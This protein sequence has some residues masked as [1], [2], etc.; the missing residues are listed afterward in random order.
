MASLAGRSLVSSYKELLKLNNLTPNSGVSASLQTV[1]DGFAGATAL[2]LSNAGIASTGTLAVTG[3]LSVN[4]NKFNVAAASGNTSVAGSLT[5]AGDLAV[6]TNKFNVTAAS[7]NTAVAGTLAV[8]GASTLNALSATTGSFSSTLSATGNLAINTNKFTVTAASGNTAAAG[9]LSAVGDF[10]INTNKFTVTAASGN[11]SSAGTLSVTGDLNVNTSKF[12]VL[13]STGNTSISG[14]LTVADTVDFASTGA[15]RIPRGTAGQ[16]PAGDTG[17]LRFNTNTQSFEG[18]NGVAWGAIGG[19]GGVGTS[20]YVRQTFVATAGQTSFTVT[21]GYTPDSVDVFQNGVKLVNGSGN[22]V[23]ITSGTAVVLATGAAAG[24][25]ID[26]IGLASGNFA[27]PATAKRQ[28]FIATAS[29]T[30]FTVTGG[31]TPNQLDVFQNGT[32]LVTSVDVDVSNGSTF[33]LTTPAVAGDSLEVVGFTAANTIAGTLKFQAGTAAAPSITRFEDENTGIFFPA[34]DT[35]AFSEGGAEAMRIDSSGQVGIGGT[36]ST[37]LH[38]QA[39]SPSLRIQAASGNSGALDFYRTASVNSGQIASEST[40]ALVFS[41]NGVGNSGL[42]ERLRIDSSGRVGIGTASPS[43]TLEVVGNQII[44]NT[45]D[46]DGSTQCALGIGRNTV[47]GDTFLALGTNQTNDYS[48]IQSQNA[49]NPTYYNL[50]LNPKGGNVKIGTATELLSSANRLEVSGTIGIGI[51]ADGGAES[52]CMLAWNS[53]AS[54]NNMFAIFYTEASPS[55]VGSIDFNRASTLTRYNTTSDATLKNI[56]GD[57]SGEESV[58]ILKN[59]KIRD[60]TWKKDATNKVN[61]GVVAQELYEVFKGAVSEGG[62]IVS[63]DSDGNDITTY[64]PWGVDKT[65][66]TFHLVA[67]W[68]A[69]EKL[70]QELKSENDSLKSRIE[71]LEAA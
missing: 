30:V 70:I 28:N 45:S 68:Q 69:H 59:T 49:G 2:Q 67:G 66:F 27:G 54:G 36:P 14:T 58:S 46:Q 4:T 39:T 15:M 51:K 53:A 32:K 44:K 48:F 33:T 12:S 22:D 64:R 21:G 61:V 56:I 63:K 65:A 43:A 10:A 71:A 16:R 29:Q 62:D 11:V 47:A 25:V 26:V 5:A 57:S 1:E 20:Q 23:T 7:G 17:M 40:N 60:Y 24:D 19:S 42:A 13:A 31:Y 8:T 6:N 50:L 35:I 55:S 18:H 38:L 34:A 9:T 3:D 41:T 37:L 52:P